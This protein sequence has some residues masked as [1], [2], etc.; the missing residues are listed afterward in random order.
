MRY[1][2]TIFFVLALV[3][4]SS[5][6]DWE[7]SLAAKPDIDGEINGLSML[8]DGQTGWAIGSSGGY[9]MILHTTNGWA[10]WV[11][12][13]DTNVTPATF[14]DVSFFDALNG[15][16]VGVNGTIIH[17]SDG[18]ENW[19]IQGAGL[20]TA[21]VK[22]VCAV[23]ATVA[24]AA[25]GS[26]TLLYT[27]NGVD[28]SV[29]ATGATGDF[30]GID[31][32]DATH[33]IAVGEAQT[34]YYTTNGTTWQTASTIPNIGGKDFNAVAMADQNTAWA[35]GD[36]FE[37]LA[38]KSVFAKSTDGG[39][40]WTLWENS[41]RIMENMWAIDFTSPTKG[42]AVG[43]KGWVFTTTDGN[44]WT[45]LTRISG[46]SNEAARIVGDRI[47]IMGG[48]G[49]MYGSEDFGAT[50]QSL[51]QVNAQYQYKI[52]AIDNDRIMSIGY[53]SSMTLT[54]DGGAN[55]A[56][57]FVVAD[58]TISLQLWGI[59]YANS[60]VG[61]VAGSGGFIA[62][63]TD[64]GLN[65]FLPGAGVTTQWLR[66][67]YAFDENQVW[68][69]GASGTIL[70]SE[71]G[72][73]DWTIQGT[74]I[75][76]QTLYDIDGID[77][78]KLVIAGD[79]SSFLY[80]TDGGL[81]WKTAAHDLPGETKI[82]DLFFLDATHGWAVGNDGA[83]LFSGDTGAT[84]A[85]KN[86]PTS[87]DLS[88]V[89]FISETTGWI[90]GEDGSIFETTDAGVMWAPVA[91]GLTDK[92][93]KSIAVTDDD[94][95]FVC[96]YGGIIIRFGPKIPSAV[97]YTNSE[98][99]IEGF[100]LNQNYPNPFN[101]RTEIRYS[102]SKACHSEIAIF[103]LLGEKVTTLVSE[104]QQPGRYAVT[105]DGRNAS[106]EKVTSGVYLFTL[107]AGDFYQM[108]KMLFLK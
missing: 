26:G 72:G 57:D 31:M 95:V 94:K 27:I 63:T 70:K 37:V 4:I 84:W 105:W 52:G 11:D 91:T 67:V 3:T 74:G 62:K 82:S 61:W 48:A 85:K 75:S 43:H 28:W 40:T 47:W 77:Q 38:L 41:D 21:T 102:L 15:W 71:N 8:P 104:F 83:I 30:Y 39:N 86:S 69:V 108:K 49:T 42:V 89:G 73:T 12:Q 1:I 6:Q 44:E 29:I 98:T 2:I 50:W 46:N 106:N 80:T 99:T 103:N 33:G 17:T 34:I 58:N 7:W 14:S 54:T 51:S 68:I 55:W 90:A 32:F 9:G 53:A 16:V 81:N 20:T 23:S 87:L 97:V 35:V 56:S 60:N 13:S 36:G 22:G 19:E 78:N 66:A 5:A 25:A 92:D 107:K 10:D 24:Y 88:G 45:P 100:E 18:G 59:D 76:T 101:P 79:R 64:G 65:W 96:G 93:M